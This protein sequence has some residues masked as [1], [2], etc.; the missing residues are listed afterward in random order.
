MIES[1]L[2]TSREAAEF[3]KISRTSL[4]RLCKEGS[5]IPLRVRSRLHF[6]KAGLERFILSLSDHEERGIN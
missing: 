6:E 5:L 1:P 4:W 2:F 3:L